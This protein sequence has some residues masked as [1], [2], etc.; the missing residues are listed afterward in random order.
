MSQKLRQLI[1]YGLS[2][3]ITLIIFVAAGVFIS[4]LVEAI[5]FPPP[6]RYHVMPVPAWPRPPIGDEFFPGF[7]PI[8]STS[9]DDEM[10]PLSNPD[11]NSVVYADE[12]R[13][14]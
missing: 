4:R 1:A 14:T 7:A 6:P 10:I 5:F 11:E 9:P 8:P 12:K 13:L 3:L 2:T